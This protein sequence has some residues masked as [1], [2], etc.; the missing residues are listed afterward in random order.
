MSVSRARLLRTYEGEL[1]RSELPAGGRHPER[2]RFEALLVELRRDPA[3]F[4]APAALAA[5]AGV[6]ATRLQRGFR[7]HFHTTPAQALLAARLQRAEEL[8]ACGEPV[9]DAAF[10]AGF[11]T[12]S[13][14]H[15]RFLGAT[16]LT[17]GAFRELGRTPDFVLALPRDFLPG[18]TLRSWGRDPASLTERVDGRRILRTFRTN[19]GTSA[20]AALLDIELALD[21]GAAS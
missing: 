14:F 11:S 16:G 15:D 21:A 8:L 2:E 7:E 10:R 5:R 18:P 1:D 9:A 13:T 19:S 20:G 17:P 4:T 6:G 3:A 12:L